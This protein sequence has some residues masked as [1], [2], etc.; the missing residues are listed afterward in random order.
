VQAVGVVAV[1]AVATT[2]ASGVTL[3]DTSPVAVDG[4][5]IATIGTA[6]VLATVPAPISV[7]AV[8]ATMLM[9][10]RRSGVASLWLSTKQ[11]TITDVNAAKAS[12]S[13]KVGIYP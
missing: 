13:F 1:L 3:F 12:V 10:A 6:I 4:T 7:V 9:E 11:A 8:V 5:S 2:S